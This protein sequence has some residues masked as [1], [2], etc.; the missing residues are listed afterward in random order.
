M[1]SPTSSSS[2][3]PTV[4]GQGVDPN[5]DTLLPHLLGRQPD[6]QSM[7]SISDR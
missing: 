7:R 3:P 2:K 6:G 1:T 5:V 4:R